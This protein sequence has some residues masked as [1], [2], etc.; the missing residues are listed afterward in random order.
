MNPFLTEKYQQL[1]SG[2]PLALVRQKAWERFLQMG[3]PQRK[4]STGF[5]YVPLH[6]LYEKTFQ[7]CVALDIEQA[8]FLDAIYPQCRES[9]LVFVDGVFRPDFSNTQGIPTQIV[10]TSLEE[11]M[12]F[13][14]SVLHGHLIQQ[15]SQ[16][17]DAFA[18]L[19][20]SLHERGIFIYVPPELDIT[21]P[22]QIL[23]VVSQ[24]AMPRIQVFVGA[25]SKVSFISN[26]AV[27]KPEKP[28]V[29]SVI[30]F[31][32]EKGA[33][34]HHVDFPGCQGLH[35]QATR[36]H[37][38]RESLLQ[39]VNV[40]TEAQLVR[41]DYR[42]ALCGEQARADL[43]GI[44]MLKGNGQAHTHVLMEHKAP[45]AHS[46]QCFKGVLYDASQSSFEGKIF[47]DADAQKTE[48]YQLNNNL[49]L[50]ENALANSK[51]NLE[52]L[53]DDVKASH[54]ATVGQ[55]DPQQLFYLKTR[56]LPES[57]AKQLLVQGFCKQIIDRILHL[58][59]REEVASLL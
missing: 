29:N 49:I 56:G 53:A 3:L 12:P 19:N 17:K 4:G 30:D 1:S 47:V 24:D 42:V 20:L 54:G 9:F 51:P 44:W 59:L 36:A 46:M 18:L 52:I 8:A 35:F 6:Q 5:Q 48:A 31:F 22:I 26:V 23:H 41:N 40:V 38:K 33:A 55:L 2:G 57:V 50:G 10:M 58:F 34:V 15:I 37:L 14:G 45:H 25:H 21:I 43:Q 16:E 28:W 27:R 11:A 32:L 13:Y 7:P 39:T